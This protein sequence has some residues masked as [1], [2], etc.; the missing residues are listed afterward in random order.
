[1]SDIVVGIDLGTSNSV[2]SVVL[3]GEPLVIPDAAGNRIQPSVIYFHEDGTTDVGNVAVSYLLKDPSHTV[4][5]AKRL[6]GRPFDSPE[7]RV[8][9]GSF[10]FKIVA[11]GDGAPR[12]NMY[13][14][15]HPPEG[16]SA[17]VLVHLKELAENYL[18]MPVRKAVITVP[19]NFDEGQRRATKRAGELA[20]LEVMRLVNEPTAAALAY[21]YGQNRRERVAIYDFGG[22]TFDITILELRG[23][24]FQVLSTAGN[25]Y[26]GGDD[27]DHRLVTS[28]LNAFERQYGYD[29]TG[30]D[31]IKQRLKA[32][33]QDIKHKLSDQEVVTAR[34]SEMV[35]GTL[36]ELELEFSLTREA[37]NKRT[38]D[39]VE[40][41]LQTCE[42]A[43]SLAGL[44]RA[45]IDHL[46]LVGGTT[47]IPLVNSRVQEFF[48]RQ[49]VMNINPDE[50][51]A[52]GAAIF[53]QSMVEETAAPPPPRR[54][55]LP[56]IPSQQNEDF[57]DD[58][59]M[60]D[61]DEAELTEIRPGDE[62]YEAE[63]TGAFRPGPSKAPSGLPSGIP[64]APRPPARDHFDEPTN[65]GFVP[66]RAPAPPPQPSWPQAPPQQQY[67]P[68]Q[69]QHQPQQPA[70]APPPST[71]PPQQAYQ[72]P[73]G[74]FSG[75]A[76]LLIDVTP[77]ALGVAT[78][79]GVMDIIIERNGSLP[80]ARTRMFS[81]AR[82]DQTRV[83]LPIFSGNSRRIEDN[84]QL[85]VLEL[86]EIPPGPREEVQIE[87]TFEVDTNGMLNVRATDMRTGLNQVARISILGEAEDVNY[88]DSDN[89][90]M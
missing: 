42:E 79:G 24:V 16:I 26:L 66:P 15:M 63:P 89:L 87:V 7:L 34:V 57:D 62:G 52:V 5:S 86:T 13:G 77:H 69:P 10:P 78:V 37:F 20:G 56:P 25:S 8:L 60:D 9:I 70:Y 55:G 29:L 82:D 22:G 28:M 71:A 64:T 12:I 38:H 80:L 81:T 31:A 59:W 3:E 61:L 74:G 32:V 90:L 4:Y 21:G 40:T 33:A 27:F 46:V 11:S 47:R 44:Q 23:N 67:Q 45:E 65:H 2:I 85:G 75:G 17:R 68:P 73:A 84:R 50:V 41:S 76:P 58:A 30:E 1:M 14:A 35:P 83:V 49:A 54:P 88:Y 53:G 18:G 39:I 43:L 51:V 72:A 6:I 19:A 36:T 48:N